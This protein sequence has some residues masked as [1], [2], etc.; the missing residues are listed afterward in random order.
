MAFQQYEYLIGKF[1]DGDFPTGQD[2]NDLIDSTYNFSL[3]NLPDLGLFLQSA[4]GNWEST[5]QTYNA[6]SADYATFDYVNDN[7]LNLA[8]GSIVGSLDINQQILSGGTDL[9]NLFLTPAVSNINGPLNINQQI[10]SGGA[11]L[12][13]LFLSPA[14]GN[15]SG[16]LNIN[17]QILS[18][19]IDLYNLFLTPAGGNINGSLNVNQQILSG[20]VDLFSLFSSETTELQQLVYNKNDNQLQITGGNSVSLSALDSYATMVFTHAKIDPADSTTYYFG[21]I[22]SVIPSTASKISRQA[23]SQFTGQ[24]VQASII[25]DRDETKGSNQTSTFSIKNVTRG[26]TAQVSSTV[27]YESSRT[28]IINEGLGSTQSPANWTSNDVIFNGIV[29]DENE[30]ADINSISSAH[31]T[32]PTINAG[33]YTALIVSFQS[34]FINVEGTPTSATVQY[35]LNNGSSY[36]GNL[37]GTTSSI[38]WSNSSVVVSGVNLNST[39]KIRFINPNISNGQIRV[40]NVIISGLSVT[41]TGIQNYTITPLA[42]FS[43]DLLEVIWSTPA[44]TENPVEVTNLLTA[45]IKLSSI[46]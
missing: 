26:Q 21:S 36:L 38:D 22:P 27:S 20:G 19:G 11:D 33:A 5:Y 7:F 10:L 45:K 9:Y 8:G 18:G 13:N 17:Q 28:T 43:G 30:G 12:Y 40:R 39:A 24:I 23:V 3:S 34:K 37:I 44:W 16:S 42:V 25:N 2:F 32:T 4:S 6:L 41:S 35:S 29:N 31:L 15:I 1:E 14:G 46:P